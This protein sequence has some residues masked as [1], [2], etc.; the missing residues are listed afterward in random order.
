MVCGWHGHRGTWCL[1]GT[2]LTSAERG[3]WR[4]AVHRRWK[5]VEGRPD[6]QHQVLRGRLLVRSLA[7]WR[8]LVSDFR[9]KLELRLLRP[10]TLAD[11]RL[12]S[13]VLFQK[14]AWP[15]GPSAILEDSSC[16]AC[17]RSALPPALWVRGLPS[18]R[19]S[20]QEPCPTP[21]PGSGTSPCHSVTL[22]ERCREAPEPLGLRDR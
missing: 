19:V 16:A 11:I 10:W 2:V 4:T 3:E 21:G 22:T 12:G 1:E 7:P 8:T 18:V 15:P 17:V 9:M 5:V 13:R 6:R 20:G 14:P